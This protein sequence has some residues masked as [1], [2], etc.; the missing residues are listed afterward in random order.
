MRIVDPS[1]V[2]EGTVEFLLWISEC[3]FFKKIS[4]LFEK[5]II[6]ASFSLI[7][8]GKEVLKPGNKKKEITIL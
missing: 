5:N 6:S 2:T 1:T 7:K 8:N 3:L 4:T